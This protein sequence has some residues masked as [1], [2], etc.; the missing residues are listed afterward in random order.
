MAN[1]E[2]TQTS[3]VAVGSMSPIEHASLYLS[4]SRS[5]TPEAVSW[6]R[7]ITARFA[8]SAGIG[9]QQLEDLRLLVSEAVTNVVLH[10]YEGSG[11]GEVH[12]IAAVVPGELWIVVADD[13]EGMRTEPGESSGLGL[14]L[15][16]MA[17][18]SDNLTIAS[19]SNGGVEVRMMFNLAQPGKA[20]SNSEDR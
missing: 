10:A 20:G 14:G 7:D 3:R 19:R 5:A 12:V 6:A 13:G 11:G 15:A 8:A 17:Q 1:G 4:E 16:L 18:L 9:A 2:G